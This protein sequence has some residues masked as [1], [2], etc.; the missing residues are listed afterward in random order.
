MHIQLKAAAGTHKNL[1]DAGIGIVSGG[2]GG[3]AV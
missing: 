3:V 1:T 2:L